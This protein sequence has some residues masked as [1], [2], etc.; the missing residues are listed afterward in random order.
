MIKIFICYA[1]KDSAFVD[2]LAS[3]FDSLGVNTF[4]AK[5]SIKVGESI[6]EKINE[7]LGS[8][9]HLI[10][11]L[12]PNFV[13]SE[14]AKRELNSSLMRQLDKKEIMIKPVL[15]ENCEIPPLLADIKYADFR[16]D[17]N[18]GFME[19]IDS[20]KNDFEIESYLQVVEN[21]AKKMEITHDHRFLAILL[22]R[23]SPFS[24]VTMRIFSMLSKGDLVSKSDVFNEIGTGDI[25]KGQI[26]LL[27]EEKFVEIKNK[28]KI[29]ISSLGYQIFELISE[30]VIQ[31][32][33]EVVCT[34]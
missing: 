31:A 5:W 3:S 6:V 26:D 7:A 15:K 17:F 20:F 33:I 27:I 28:D 25:V 24:T 9:D 22:K 29:K 2:K 8:Q 30:G 14:W 12:S 21:V 13:N 16:N 23:L 18:H 1:G 32:V 10:V 11:V 19:L 34:H 4:Y